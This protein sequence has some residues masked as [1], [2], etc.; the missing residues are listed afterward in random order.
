MKYD[1][2]KF[3]QK[4]N[5]KAPV[6]DVYSAWITPHHLE[7]WLVRQA[8]FKDEKGGLLGMRDIVH[9]D[10]TYEWLWYGHPDNHIDKGKVLYANGQNKLQFS[11]TKGA[12]VT[13]DIGEV[14]GETIVMLTQENIP[15]DEEGR[16]AYHI[17]NLTG[18]TFYLCNLKSYME[19]GIDL[20]NRNPLFSNVANA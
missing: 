5:V 20:R 16:I 15:T 4:I 6:E 9:K 3:T 8:A 10:Y 13:I 7:Q 2:S 14:M 17:G 1:W 19:G 11:F 12:V 18:W